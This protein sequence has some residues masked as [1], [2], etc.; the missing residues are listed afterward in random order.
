MYIPGMGWVDAEEYSGLEDLLQSIGTLDWID[1]LFD[2][3]MGLAIL[4]GDLIFIVWVCFEVILS[5]I[6]EF[7][8]FLQLSF[9]LFIKFGIVGIL[10]VIVTIL[11]LLYPTFTKP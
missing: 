10:A 3:L 4:F 9:L 8:A 7:T 5:G 11:E 1:D 6:M 2:I